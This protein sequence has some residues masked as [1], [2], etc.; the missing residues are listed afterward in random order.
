MKCGFAAESDKI[1]GGIVGFCKGCST[2][3]KTAA[4]ENT[5]PTSGFLLIAAFLHPRLFCKPETGR[6]S[7]ASIFQRLR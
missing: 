3:Q 2:E 5:C 6:A 4:I 1:V 7:A